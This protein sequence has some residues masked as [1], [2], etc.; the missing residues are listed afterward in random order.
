MG[1]ACDARRGAS[2][3]AGAVVDPLYIDSCP[4]KASCMATAP[5]VAR[6]SQTGRSPFPAVLRIN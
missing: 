6:P 2:R 5:R 1:F 3:L 4:E